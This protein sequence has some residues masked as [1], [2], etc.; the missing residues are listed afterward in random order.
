[1]Y[2]GYL[3]GCLNRTDHSATSLHLDDKKRLIVLH[4]LTVP[5]ENLPYDPRRLTFDLVHELH[6]FD[7]TQRIAGIDVIPDLD[8]GRRIGGWGFVERAD[9]GRADDHLFC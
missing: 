2:S 3:R 8:E 7:D 4:R 6:G 1:M 5:N 9:D